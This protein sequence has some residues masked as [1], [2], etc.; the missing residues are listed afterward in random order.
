LLPVEV[1]GRQAVGRQLV[2]HPGRAVASASGLSPG[3]G[4]SSSLKA[5]IRKSRGILQATPAG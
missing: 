5:R 1:R 2:R 3:T 4:K